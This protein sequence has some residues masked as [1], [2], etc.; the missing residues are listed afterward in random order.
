[1]QTDSIL[2]RTLWLFGTTLAVVVLM[3]A[4]VIWWL[5]RHRSEIT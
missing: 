2:N 3:F 4:L 5:R 1:M